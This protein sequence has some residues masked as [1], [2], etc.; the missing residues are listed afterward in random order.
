MDLTY[1]YI[2]NWMQ[3]YFETYN[4]YAQHP[5]TTN[6]MCEFF[7]EDLQFTP[8]VSGLKG[9][10]GRAAFLRS[11][12]SHPSHIEKLKPE[13]III[14]VVKKTVA[15]LA[16]TELTDTHSGEI[17]VVDRYLVR[18]QL[19]VDADDTL[20]IRQMLL[21][22]KLLSPEETLKLRELIQRDPVTAAAFDD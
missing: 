1:D 5:A 14:D 17:A 4:R 15:V 22:K 12:S 11:V 18:Y 10:D 2:L 21:F 9:L 6:R 8:A 7:T 3:R 20:K 19:V 13:D 16:T